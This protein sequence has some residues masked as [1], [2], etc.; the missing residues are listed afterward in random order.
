MASV[1]G[2]PNCT[3]TLPNETGP[4]PRYYLPVRSWPYLGRFGLNGRRRVNTTSKEW[5]MSG[6][7]SDS[8]ENWATNR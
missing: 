7:L 3:M 4:M 8:L 5:T 1:T 6:L 2:S